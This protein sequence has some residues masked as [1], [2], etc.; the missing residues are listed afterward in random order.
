MISKV[1]C[2]IRKLQLGRKIRIEGYY[3]LLLYKNRSIT[4]KFPI[5]TLLKMMDSSIEN[6]EKVEYDKENCV[7]REKIQSGRKIRSEGYI[8]WPQFKNRSIT[9]KFLIR[10]YL[11][12]IDSNIKNHGEVEYDKENC[13]Q[14]GKIQSGRKIPSEGK[15]IIEYRLNKWPSSII[16][17][18]CTRLARRTY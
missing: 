10:T 2:N 3:L 15:E 6:N 11:E 18:S 9:K 17:F 7:Q 13:V 14:R 5:K 1:N 12:M 4:K 8:L 16:T